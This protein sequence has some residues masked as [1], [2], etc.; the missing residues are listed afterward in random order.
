MAGN[1]GSQFYADPVVF[2]VLSANVDKLDIKVHRGATISGIVVIESSDAR[3]SLDRF[4]QLMLLVMVK[5]DANKSPSTGNC[6]VGPD[7]SFRLGGLKPGKATIRPF[8]IS[9]RPPG[10]LRVERNGV[11]VQGAFEIQPN[12][13]ISGVRVV[14]TPATG[15][16][17]GRVTISGGTLQTGAKIRAQARSSSAEP[18]DFDGPF[19]NRPVEVSSNGSFAIENLTPGVYEVEVFATVP[20]QRGSRTVSAKQNVTV[21]GDSPVEVD[22]VLDLSKSTEK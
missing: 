2:E 21:T 17:R 8:A 7:G 11:E 19:G 9:A 10:L 15:V 4:G 6:L 12:E 20:G 1:G 5:D 3:D 13:E 22:L 14:L 16:I 18:S